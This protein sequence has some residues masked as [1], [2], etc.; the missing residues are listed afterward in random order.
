MTSRN[1]YDAYENKGVYIQ[2]GI[3]T[4]L[5]NLFALAIGV[6]VKV[7]YDRVLPSNALTS[8]A[9]LFIGAGEEWVVKESFSEGD[10]FVGEGRRSRQVW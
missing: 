4:L 10:A 5:V 3:A 1:S 7:V 8:L 2:G 6:F 9:G